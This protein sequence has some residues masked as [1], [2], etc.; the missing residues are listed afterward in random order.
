MVNVHV[1][2]SRMFAYVDFMEETA[3]KRAVQKAQTTPF[4]VGKERLAVDLKREI[5]KSFG[6]KHRSW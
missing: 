6:K 4:Y 2:E 3:A 5:N 1:V